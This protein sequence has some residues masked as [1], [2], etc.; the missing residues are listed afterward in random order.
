MA[1]PWGENEQWTLIS[2]LCLRDANSEPSGHK[3]KTELLQYPPIFWGSS[4]SC[5]PQWTPQLC[6]H[7]AECTVM[8]NLSYVYVTPVQLVNTDCPHKT[9]LTY[10]KWKT[11]DQWFCSHENNLN[12]SFS[13]DWIYPST[14]IC[15]F[16]TLAQ[17]NP[18]SAIWLHK[19]C[20][21]DRDV[22]IW[23]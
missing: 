2:S 11:M 6:S 13:I 20:D 15:F 14:F 9:P 22:V 21:L 12:F 7:L 19:G 10:C 18:K 8:H 1:C 5:Y 23:G 16:S 3:S 17:G 4:P